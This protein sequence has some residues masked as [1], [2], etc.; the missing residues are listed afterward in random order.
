MTLPAINAVTVEAVL[1]F[2]ASR[3]DGV[4]ARE[5]ATAVFGI[6]ETRTTARGYASQILRVCEALGYV[7]SENVPERMGSD[8]PR[9]I[10]RALHYFPE[11]VESIA[12]TPRFLHLM[13]CIIERGLEDG[14]LGNPATHALLGHLRREYDR[15]SLVRR[16]VPDHTASP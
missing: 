13:I 1:A 11:A 12:I 16:E 3:K 10:Y 9:K 15:I 2:V 8:A 6:G 5:V 4:T 7:E 14:T